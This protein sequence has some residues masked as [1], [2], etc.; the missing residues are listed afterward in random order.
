ML[1]VNELKKKK[2]YVEKQ[3]PDFSNPLKKICFLMI[4]DVD[5][6]LLNIKSVSV[7]IKDIKHM[8]YSSEPLLVA[9]Y[10]KVSHK[11]SS[12]DDEEYITLNKKGNELLIYEL[13]KSY[14]ILKEED[15]NKTVEELLEEVSRLELRIQ[16]I[17]ENVKIRTTDWLSKDWQVKL[18]EYKK[19]C[20]MN[21][22][23]DIEFKDDSLENEYTTNENN[24]KLMHN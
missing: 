5:T 8:C 10:V 17:R 6:I 23:T 24:S 15:L 3:Q 16:N 20:I 19:E 13:I 9:L 18:L 21:L 1:I 12:M 2:E 22:L 11:L 14:W 7:Q 4:K